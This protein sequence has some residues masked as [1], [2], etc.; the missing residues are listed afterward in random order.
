MLKQLKQLKNDKYTSQQY[1]L[2]Q[3]S[4]TA[5]QESVRLSRELL[6]TQA[7][8]TVNGPGCSEWEDL[9][10][11]VSQCQSKTFHVPHGHRETFPHQHMEMT[12]A[13]IRLTPSCPLLE[14]CRCPFTFLKE[15]GNKQK[16][17]TWPQHLYSVCHS[18]SPTGLFSS[19]AELHRSKSPLWMRHPLQRNYPF[20]ALTGCQRSSWLLH[21]TDTSLHQA[22]VNRHTNR[23]F[24]SY[25][26]SAIGNYKVT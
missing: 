12:E 7:G 1:E 16:G 15:T 17:S 25:L 13:I 3:I 10:R 19:A 18:F 26:T 8:E 6:R 5:F 11:A 24:Q 14:D 9:E 23:T 22:H 2:H 20:R 21:S 4:I